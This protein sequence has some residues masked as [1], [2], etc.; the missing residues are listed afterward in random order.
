MAWLQR[1]KSSMPRLAI[2]LAALMLSSSALAV[3]PEHIPDRFQQDTTN[4][5]LQENRPKAP[6]ASEVLP[7]LP[8]HQR[9]F[10]NDYVKVRHFRD[11]VLLADLIHPASRR[12]EN[13][14]NRDYYD[15]LRMFYLTEEIPAVFRLQI[16]EIDPKKQDALQRRVQMPLPPTHVMFI[17][18]GEGQNIE[19]LQRY[20]REEKEPKLKLYELVK[21][22]DEATL[23]EFRQQQNSN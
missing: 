3:E 6:L 2:A 16:L 10:V 23:K 14:S 5:Y 4:Y 8:A 1:Q 12:C 15:Y 9:Q 18:Y 22:P 21:C 7:K 19:G 17:E 20:L 11:D 13:D